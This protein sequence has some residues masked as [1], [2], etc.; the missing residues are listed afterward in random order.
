VTG[1]GGAGRALA[2]S[3]AFAALAGGAAAP[4]AA[5]LPNGPG[6]RG[7]HAL[8]VAGGA[9]LA[10]QRDRVLSPLRYSGRGGGG[11]LAYARAGGR[12]RLGARAAYAGARLEPAAAAGGQG[13]AA[14]R[15]SQ[16]AATLQLAALARVGAAGP[17]RALAGATVEGATLGAAD[18]VT[19]AAFPGAYRT[20][21]ASAFVTLRPTVQ[22][23]AGGRT[24]VAYAVA[25]ALVGVVWRQFAPGVWGPR[26]AAV[27]PG[28]LGAV[29]QAVTLAHDVGPRLAV[30]AGYRAAF[31][32]V[33]QLGTAPSLALADER[34]TVG[35]A[36]RRPFRA[37]GPGAR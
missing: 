35:V 28:T 6:P 4:A 9:A 16:R 5:Q 17:V 25:P 34:V 10:A 18:H 15:R 27:G 7:G 8:A 26:G 14:V 33:R 23:E 3:A 37:A 29:E 24:R 11:E 21:T 31:W 19:L 32:R 1:R 12:V 2:A 20:P 36:L 13:V 30:T 22:L